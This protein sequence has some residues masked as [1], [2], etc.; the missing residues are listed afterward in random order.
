M[1]KTIA[2]IATI[3]TMGQKPRVFPKAPSSVRDI[4]SSHGVNGAPERNPRRDG[5]PP[6]AAE[7]LAEGDF[8]GEIMIAG[9][10][11]EPTWT[12]EPV[13]ARKPVANTNPAVGRNGAYGP[14][15][16]KPTRG[17]PPGL[18]SRKPWQEL[19]ISRAT[20]FRRRRTEP[21]V[22]DDDRIDNAVVA[23]A[24][25]TIGRRP[26]RQTFADERMLQ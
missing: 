7:A 14:C 10:R 1:I 24:Q 12:P 15:R 4:L 13:V 21:W 16:A 23:D 26:H 20:W 3:A 25:A 17:R 9:G 18:A 11:S 5:E 8:P 2:E 19:G 22:A 6:H